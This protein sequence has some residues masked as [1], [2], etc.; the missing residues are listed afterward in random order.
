MTQDQDTKKLAEDFVQQPEVKEHIKSLQSMKDVNNFTR[1]LVAPLLQEMMEAELTTTLGYEKHSPSGTHSGNSRNGYRHR[2]VAGTHGEA[3]LAV[4]RDRNGDYEPKILKEYSGILNNE[5]EEK[6]ISLYVRGLSIRDVAA[7]LGE[8]YHVEVSDQMISNVT[9]RI[10][11]LL[12]EW[13]NRPLESI[14]PIVYLDGI[15]FKVRSGGKVTD[16]L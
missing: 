4:P 16:K 1:E 10:L 3:D 2:R 12:K 15:R 8:L 11:P 9:D 5:I 7:Q 14:Y 13:Q 6:I